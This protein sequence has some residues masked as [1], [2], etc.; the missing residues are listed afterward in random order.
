MTKTKQKTKDK[1]KTQDIKKRA[2]DKYDGHK[3]N[4]TGRSKKKRVRK[5]TKT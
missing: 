1:R 5:R 3:A 2:K 4:T